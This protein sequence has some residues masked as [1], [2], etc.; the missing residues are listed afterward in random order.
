MFGKKPTWEIV[1]TRNGRQGKD[2]YPDRMTAI[3]SL[4]LMW[5]DGVVADFVGY[6]GKEIPQAQF[7]DLYSDAILLMS[8]QKTC[9]EVR[10]EF[11]NLMRDY[12]RHEDTLIKHLGI[13]C[14]GIAGRFGVEPNALLEAVVRRL[15]RGGVMNLINQTVP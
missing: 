12:K 7:L 15:S 10:C 8:L 13:T 3:T 11:E 1:H 5:E 2:V 9:G 4:C 6:C 14:R